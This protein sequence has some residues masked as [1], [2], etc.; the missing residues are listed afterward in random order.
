MDKENANLMV[1]AITSAISGAVMGILFAPD[2]GSSTRRKISKSSEEYLQSLKK[3][4]EELRQSLSEQ[5]EA[6]KEEA[7][8][9]TEDVKEKGEDMAEETAESM[10]DAKESL[11]SMTKED[12][13][14]RAK[15]LSVDGYSN[16]SK[17]ELIEALKS[18]K[19]E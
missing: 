14:E 11:E 17:S 19:S 7:K 2:K 8:E 4:M 5:V 12:L 3:D 16:M 18:S 1:V 9:M 15:E 13:Y 6:T 10:Q